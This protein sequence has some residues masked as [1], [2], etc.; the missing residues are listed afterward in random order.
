VGI[1]FPSDA[2][3]K[4]TQ[5]TGMLVVSPSGVIVSDS[6]MIVVNVQRLKSDKSGRDK[7]IRETALESNKYPTV[8]FVPMSF[9]GLSAKPG[10]TAATF[11]VVGHM[12]VHGTMRP[13]TW[14]VSAHSEGDDV[15][16]TAT[17]R[18]PFEYFGITPPKKSVLAIPFTVGDMIKLEYDFRLVPSNP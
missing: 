7:T 18:F 6:S 5:V 13:V 15:V 1:N 9:V 16:G 12:T 2:I 3:G 14:S 10:A 17:T 11:S 4:T 8:E